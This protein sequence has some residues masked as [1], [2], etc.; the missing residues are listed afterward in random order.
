MMYLPFKPYI[1]GQLANTIHLIGPGFRDKDRPGQGHSKEINYWTNFAVW[2]SARSIGQD[3]LSE[4]TSKFD[5]QKK[6]YLY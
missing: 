2:T 5:V 3:E 6:I 1:T 4:L